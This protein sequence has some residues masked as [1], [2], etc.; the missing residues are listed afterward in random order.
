MNDEKKE[1][2]SFVDVEAWRNEAEECAKKLQKGRGVRVI[3]RLKQDRWE[4]PEG[5][6]RSKL[7]IVAEHVYIKN[8]P[9]PAEG[10]KEKKDDILVA[11]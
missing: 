11:V 7:K 9:R 3:G 1:E 10:D 8:I 5:N 6:P 4:D 2:V